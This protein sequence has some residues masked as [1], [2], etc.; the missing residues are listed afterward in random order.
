MVKVLFDTNILIDYVQG[1]P[2]ARAEVAGYDDAVISV[3]NWM[4]TCCRMTAQQKQDFRMDLLCLGVL[5]AHTNDDI[6]ERATIYRGQSIAARAKVPIPDYLIRATADSQ[7]RVIVTRNPADFGGEGPMV[8]V[9][10]KRHP[11]TGAA[12]DVKPVP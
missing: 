11:K 9:P 7:G 4:E 12:Y 5:I 1:L 10:Y 2:E 3:M 6:M 8:R